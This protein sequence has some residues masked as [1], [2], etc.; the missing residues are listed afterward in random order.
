[1]LPNTLVSRFFRAGLPAPKRY[2]VFAGLVRAAR[3]LEN[4]G[5]S[6]ADVATHLDH[7]SPQ[8]FGRHVRT[9]LAISATE[10]RE[11]FDG[12]RMMERMRRDLIHPYRRELQSLS[13]LVMRPRSARRRVP[14][15]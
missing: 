4:P 11:R 7:S 15:S 10:F 2:L 5:L 6:I 14:V 13:P 1:V 3:L 12:V 9:Y 8:S